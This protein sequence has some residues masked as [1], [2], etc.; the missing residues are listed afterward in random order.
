MIQPKEEAHR[1][2]HLLRH[3]KSS[4]RDS[5][6]EDRDR[7]LNARGHHAA[8]LLGALLAR[9]PLPDLVLCSSAL[10]T[11]ETFEHVVRAYGRSPLVSIEDGLYLATARSLLERIEAIEDDVARLLVIG[12]NPGLHELAVALARHGPRHDR[13]RLAAKFPTAAL[14]T[15]R[16]AGSWHAISHAPIALASYVV[17]SDLDAAELDSD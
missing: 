9:Q 6:L 5:G 4:W 8:L 15:L 10:R 16:L 14:A 2:L 1:I 17:P 11:R 13:A 3:A 12:H 7:P